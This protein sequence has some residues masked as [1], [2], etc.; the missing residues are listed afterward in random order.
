MITFRK[1]D[2]STLDFI[3]TTVIKNGIAHLGDL[4]KTETI[5][6]FIRYMYILQELG[7]CECK[8][9]QDCEFA[10]KNAKTLDFKI[11]GGFEKL[12]SES[13]VES[14]LSKQKISLELNNL[15]LQ[16]ENFEYQK[17][18]RMKD[19]K[20][21]ELTTDNLRLG[22]WDIRFRWYITVGGFL[23]GIIVKYIINN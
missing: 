9:E 3:V 18:N 7:I 17:S 12:Y 23:L 1:E 4:E 16:N 8:F 21:K 20:I 22:N 5:D 2:I 15:K 14:E 19:E 13:L 10:R 6:S 11:Q